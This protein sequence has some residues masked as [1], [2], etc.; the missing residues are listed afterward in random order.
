MGLAWPSLEPV[1]LC[2]D[3]NA[4]AEADINKYKKNKPSFQKC[5]IG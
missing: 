1:G 2:F 5:C 3:M 4:E